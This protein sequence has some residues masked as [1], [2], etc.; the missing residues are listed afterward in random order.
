MF[1]K[2]ILRFAQNDIYIYGS[3]LFRVGNYLGV[4][5]SL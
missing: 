3:S 4:L 5:Y 1:N 2:E